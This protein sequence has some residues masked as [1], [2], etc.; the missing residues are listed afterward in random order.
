MLLLLRRLCGF[1]WFALLF[2]ILA[3]YIASHLAPF[4]MNP[5]PNFRGMRFLPAA[6]IVVAL[7]YIPT[8]RRYTLFSVI[9]FAFGLL[10]SFEGAIC[11]LGSYIAFLAV[12]E[13]TYVRRAR[14]LIE[15]ALLSIATYVFI[16]LLTYAF[17]GSWPRFD[18]YLNLVFGYVSVGTYAAANWLKA[19]DPHELLWV[20]LTIV[21]FGV[22]TVAWRAL[23][24]CQH[25]AGTLENRAYVARIAAVA[26]CG[27][28]LLS[29]F[30]FRSLTVYLL[31]AA[32]LGLILLFALTAAAWRN[33]SVSRTARKA[34]AAPFVLT[35]ALSSAILANVFMEK[36]PLKVITHDVSA[37]HNWVR[38]KTNVFSTA[39]HRLKNPDSDYDIGMSFPW[40]PDRL[41]EA[42][43]L[44]DRWFPNEKNLIA[45]IPE[46]AALL[47]RQGKA[48]R[49]PI[50]YSLSE[51]MTP[52]VADSVATASSKVILVEGEKLLVA[53]KISELNSLETRILM[54]ILNDWD[55][56]PVET[57]DYSTVYRLQRKSAIEP[58]DRLKLPVH[59]TVATASS[60]L[61]PLYSAAAASDW[62]EVTNWSSTPKSNPSTEWL[63]IDL[64]NIKSLKRIEII[65]FWPILDAFPS[66][67]TVLV[68][69]D[70]SSW[71]KI[72]SEER[73]HPN[74]GD[75]QTRPARG[76][77]I[78]K[79][80]IKARWIRLAM[81]A[82][83]ANSHGA[84][85][86][87]IAE[88]L[89][90]ER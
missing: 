59:S 83:Y 19:I 85:I 42:S 52:S 88:I 4:P 50:S 9:S 25:M 15:L 23:I 49:F 6:L 26:A 34:L 18:V 60:T 12:V 62:W 54:L 11:A 82:P 56:V 73:F 69:I 7:A 39:L 78:Q 30:V 35:V 55:A 41:R 70:G 58:L 77:E 76:Y 31:V 29:L 75:Y 48:D 89:A 67:F 32:P 5:Y 86:A 61:S 65:P 72:A 46:S 20:P 45:F 38:T 53:N 33:P 68:S 84:Y 51:L 37:A 74:W 47:L 14:A 22:L 17:I 36:D 13:T 21:Y 24:D 1:T 81:D 71:E 66:R 44:V 57:G 40:K 8:G 2:G 3:I 80:F 63:Q 64:G 90:F 43:K 79:S 27:T 87:Q 28:I 16:S 10:W